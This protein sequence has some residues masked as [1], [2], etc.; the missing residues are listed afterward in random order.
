MRGRP[1]NIVTET[2]KTATSTAK[3]GS[4]QSRPNSGGSSASS[5]VS[6]VVGKHPPES[7]HSQQLKIIT[8]VDGIIIKIIF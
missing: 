1:N 3:R 5:I 8:E 7:I 2:S 4:N 6:I